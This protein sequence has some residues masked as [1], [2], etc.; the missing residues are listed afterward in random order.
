MGSLD[1]RNILRESLVTPTLLPRGILT[2]NIRFER[3][4]EMGSIRTVH[5]ILR[6]CLC[7]TMSSPLSSPYLKHWQ[8]PCWSPLP[9]CNV[10]VNSQSIG[11]RR[12]IAV[13]EPPLVDN[14]I[15]FSRR[16]LSTENTFQDIRRWAATT[17][18]R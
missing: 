10:L 15:R 17:A 12:G 6:P 7:Y 8:I 16:E 14:P 5:I 1:S 9:L 18:C 11:I 13:D 3:R 4:T 2:R